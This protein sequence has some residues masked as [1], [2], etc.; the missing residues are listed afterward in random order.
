[1]SFRTKK[2]K[3]EISDLIINI[4]SRTGSTG[5]P[6]QYTPMTLYGLLKFPGGIM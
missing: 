6:T 4:R 1:M 5:H 3:D 2:K